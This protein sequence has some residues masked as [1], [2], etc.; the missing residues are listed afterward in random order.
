MREVAG[1][2][3]I[4]R[5]DLFLSPIILYRY[6]FKNLGKDRKVISGSGS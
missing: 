6:N 2:F 5:K 4:V 3:K 1:F